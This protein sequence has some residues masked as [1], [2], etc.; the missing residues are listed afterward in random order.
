MTNPCSQH[1]EECFRKILTDTPARVIDY[2]VTLD[3]V[4]SLQEKFPGM[5]ADDAHFFAEEAILDIHFR[6]T[7][8]N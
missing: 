8:V 4:R 6:S 5:G 7:D 3:L 2:G 1:A